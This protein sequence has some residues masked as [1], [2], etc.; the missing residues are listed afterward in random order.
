MCWYK[1]KSNSHSDNELSMLYRTHA[2]PNRSRLSKYVQ[3]LQNMTKHY[4]PCTAAGARW[5]C[6]REVERVC[7]EVVGCVAV[8]PRAW[9]FWPPT[10]GAAWVVPLV[11]AALP[12]RPITCPATACIK[13]CMN[14]GG[15][16]EPQGKSPPITVKCEHNMTFPRNI[17]NTYSINTLSFII[18]H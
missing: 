1:Y 15:G 18:C 16:G 9:L 12:V 3:K 4:A 10:P 17:M 6:G 7:V 14:S 5:T 2:C 13:F 11:L 8:L